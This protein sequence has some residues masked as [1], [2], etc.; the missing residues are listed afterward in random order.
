[1]LLRNGERVDIGAKHDGFVSLSGAVDFGVNARFSDTAGSKTELF[2]FFFQFFRCLK[3]FC[4]NLG[5]H[6]KMTA[7]R[8]H[9]RVD[10]FGFVQKI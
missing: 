3:F 4:G 6:M 8:Y 7:K 2:D 5:I 1:M 10:L 9:V